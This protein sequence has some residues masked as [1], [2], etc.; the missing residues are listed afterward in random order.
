M[1]KKTS[2]F[3]LK[4]VA[5]RTTNEP[6]YTTAHRNLS[7][8]F[9]YPVSWNC[10]SDRQK[11]TNTNNEKILFFLLKFSSSYYSSFCPV[12]ESEKSKTELYEMRK[13]LQSTVVV[14]FKKTRRTTM[15]KKL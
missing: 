11:S 13:F 6:Q 4:I 14:N 15:E 10:T 3:E 7:L 2:F 1:Q 9:S 5:K 12:T 8:V